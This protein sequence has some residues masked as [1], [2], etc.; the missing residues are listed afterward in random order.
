MCTVF[1]YP[2]D[3]LD[4]LNSLEDYEIYSDLGFIELFPLND[5]DKINEEYQV[6]VCV[7]DFI[8]IGTNGGGV[9]IFINKNT[10]QF[11]SI[12]FVGMNEIDAVLLADS[13]TEF[14]YK[15]ENDDLEII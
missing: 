3:Y 7:P 9:G 8:A 12:P 11:Y 13:F 5:L 15:F 4:Y 2:A 1:E 6:H 10:K 14:I